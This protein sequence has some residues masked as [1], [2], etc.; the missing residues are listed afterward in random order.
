MIREEIVTEV[1]RLSTKE[2]DL[3]KFG[4][5]MAVVFGIF[6]AIAWYKGS[7]IFPYVSVVCLGFGA[8]GIIRPMVLRKVYIGWM[9]FAI[10]IGFF[11]T[12]VILSLMFYGVFTVIGLISRLSKRDMLDQRYDADA[13]T[14]WKQHEKP[15][16]LKRHLEQQF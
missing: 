10:T 7:G 15:K 3:R 8:I 1:R 5:T 13:E 9:T 11:M 6:S 4:L 16:D 12:R 2:K 14:Y